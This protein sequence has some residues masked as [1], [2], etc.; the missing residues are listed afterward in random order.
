MLATVLQLLASG[1]AM[2]FIY[3]LVAIE[4]TLIWNTT[5]LLNFSHD[6][7]ITLGAYV[8]VGTYALHL[9]LPVPL[10]IVCSMITLWVFGAIMALCI[11]IPLRKKSSMLFAIMGT[12]LVSK[13]IVE[14]IRLIYGSFP[15]KLTGFLAGTVSLGGSTIATAYI[16]I[17]IV[18]ILLVTGLQLFLKYTKPGK[19]IRCVSQNPKAASLMGI[20][21]SRSILITT[22]LSAMICC[23]IGILIT[24]I[25][26]TDLNMSNM[27]GLK[28]FSAGVVGGFGFLPGTIAGGLLIGIVE[29]L[30]VTILPAVYKDVVAFALLILFLIIRPSG[31]MGKKA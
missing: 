4:Y 29:N 6:K 1:L 21:V 25:F 17:I 3:S 26:T 10:A 8:F 11:F 30:S 18:S 28:G 15:M 14:G 31:L 2:G 5:G 23:I 19:A 24:P 7:L 27:I 9:G 22:G 13:I 20:S 16:A 12:I